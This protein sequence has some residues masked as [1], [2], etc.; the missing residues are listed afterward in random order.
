MVSVARAIQGLIVFSTVLGVFF[1]WQAYPL[2]PG[3]VFDIL[4]FG[5]LLFLFD[6]LLT[7][8]RPTASYYLGLVL[9]VVALSETLTQPEHYA[10]VENG[11]VPATIILVVG[12]I[13]QAILIGSVVWF[14][15]S[16]R[17]RDPWA[18]PGAESPA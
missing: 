6:S 16:K 9:A 18:W 3:D 11:N 12:S 10:L 5:W 15:V 8:V 13:A 7:L 1:L 4:A 2:L 17:R 14:V